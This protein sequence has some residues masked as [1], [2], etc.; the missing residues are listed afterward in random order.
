MPDTWFFNPKSGPIV[1]DS[2]D[3]LQQNSANRRI[4]DRILLV[5]SYKI[6]EAGGNAG[7]IPDFEFVD[8][9]YYSSGKIIVSVLL[10]CYI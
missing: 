9:D 8:P 2:A 10:L 7:R 5:F 1:P 6:S 4:P 3:F